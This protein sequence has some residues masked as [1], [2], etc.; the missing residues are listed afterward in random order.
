[1]SQTQDLVEML[2]RFSHGDRVFFY[3]ISLSVPPK[4]DYAIDRYLLGS[5][6]ARYR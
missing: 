5:K 1:M 4:H 2:V 3:D 6:Q